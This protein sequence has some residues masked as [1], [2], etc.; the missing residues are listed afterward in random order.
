MTPAVPPARALTLAVALG[1]LGALVNLTPLPLGAGVDLLLGN[2]AYVLVAACLP[3]PYA[4]AAAL[5]TTLPLWAQWGHPGG[6]VTFGA[7]ALFVAT[8]RARGMRLFYVDVLY[9]SL[10][11]MPLTATM[12]WLI[13]RAPME[14]V[15]SICIKQAIN[16]AVYGSLAAMIALLVGPR[17]LAWVGAPPA[18]RLGLR[19]R[20]VYVM[21]VITAFSLASATLLSTGAT[22]RYQESLIRG[23]LA[24]TATHLARRVDDYLLGHSR[25][26]DLLSELLTRSPSSTPLAQ[27]LLAEQHRRYP[28]FLTMLVADARGSIV[29][30]AP[31]DRMRSVAAGVLPSVAD[32]DYFTAAMSRDEVFV[33]EVFR[34]RGFGSE[35]IVAISRAL[36]D[37]PGGK[38]RGI[39]EGS[40]DLRG[41][42]AIAEPDIE[43]RVV[44]VLLIDQYERVIHASPA[45]GFAPLAVY[46]QYRSAKTPEV[47]GALALEV[48]GRSVEYLYSTVTLDNGWRIVALME[49]GTVIRELNPQYVRILLLVGLAMLIAAW[50]TERAGERLAGPLER[51]AGELAEVERSGVAR[52]GPADPDASIEIERVRGELERSFAQIEQHRIELEEQVAARTRELEAVN[53]KLQALASIDALTGIGNRRLLEER[54]PVLRAGARRAGTRMAVV[55]IDLDHFKH[56]NDTHGHLAGDQCLI[57]VG[58]LL[59]AEFGRETDVVARFGGEEF[60][61]AVECSDAD[62]LSA[63]LEG[64]RQR[65]ERLRIAAGAAEPLRVTA[66]FGALMAGAEYSAQLAEWMRVAD[67][68]L[69]RAKAG[70][71]NRVEI[72][73]I[74]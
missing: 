55:L 3:A 7:E 74:S 6:L 36:R 22:V 51:L 29:A 66:S 63:K 9:W 30:T 1:L 14:Y 27:S 60:V 10:L 34:G 72:E 33:S 49:Y 57:E 37:G 12:I 38:P 62:A 56:L 42:A 41:L 67:Q 35:P 52:V 50:L 8:L 19:S 31:I 64:A 18:P 58:L 5:I 15:L 48:D 47:P 46:T 61:V 4:L 20:L 70:G 17:L 65:I 53:G 2:F 69:Y 73:A 59:V 26:L 28:G 54:F 11:G 68:S 23:S 13:G 32:R 39:V 25:G 40:L 45:L 21:T 44:Q 43:G 24:E 16:G 71:R